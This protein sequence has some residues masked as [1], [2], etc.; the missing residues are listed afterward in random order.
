MIYSQRIKDDYIMWQN[1]SNEDYLSS[2]FSN[3][4]R[5]L[6]RW[7]QQLLEDTKSRR[8]IIHSKAEWNSL[9]LSD[10]FV[11]RYRD[12][13]PSDDS[14]AEIFTLSN[15]YSNA[16]S[17]EMEKGIQTVNNNSQSLQMTTAFHTYPQRQ[18]HNRRS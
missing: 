14:A 10:S 8:C 3:E 1:V 6:V 13:K 11:P 17:D 4:N 15:Y 16:T 5:I 7:A 2:A 9:S 18:A 12:R